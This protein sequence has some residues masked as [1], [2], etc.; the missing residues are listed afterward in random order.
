MKFER[1]AD[2]SR[3]RLDIR[4]QGLGEIGKRVLHSFGG[5]WRGRVDASC[6]GRRGGD[7]V[8]ARLPFS[9]LQ[10]RGSPSE[11]YHYDCRIPPG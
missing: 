8:D 5:V 10:P 3:K 7:D 9:A 11:S 1:L 6:D 4:C 2:Y